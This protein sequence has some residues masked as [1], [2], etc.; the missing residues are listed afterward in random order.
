MA[1]GRQ[2]LTKMTKTKIVMSAFIVACT[3]AGRVSTAF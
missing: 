2:E 3:P 1:Q